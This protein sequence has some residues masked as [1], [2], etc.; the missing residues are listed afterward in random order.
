MEGEIKRVWE[1]E[2]VQPKDVGWA[3]EKSWRTLS[4]DRKV[5]RPQNANTVLLDYL[6]PGS[7]LHLHSELSS[8]THLNTWSHFFSELSPGR[9]FLFTKD[10]NSTP[11][12]LPNGETL[13]QELVAGGVIVEGEDGRER[14]SDVIFGSITQLSPP[15]LLSL[16]RGN[17]QVGFRP[18]LIILGAPEENQLVSGLL[19]DASS[20]LFSSSYWGNSGPVFSRLFQSENELVDIEWLK[21]SLW[22]A[23]MRNIALKYDLS[24]MNEVLS[25]IEIDTSVDADNRIPA[26]TALLMGWF[27]SQLQSRVVSLSA[28]GIECISSSGKK[29]FLKHNTVTEKPSQGVSSS[30]GVSKCQFWLTPAEEGGTYELPP[31][32]ICI[33]LTPEGSFETT[34]TIASDEVH[35]SGSR[36]E[37]SP[38]EAMRRYYTR[39]E[40]TATYREALAAALD[41]SDLL[42]TELTTTSER[43]WS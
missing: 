24:R 18:S 33:Q 31:S 22:R 9:I 40:S 36:N 4:S 12:V 29:W 17:L 38:E 15:V 2:P 6:E 30:R 34:L 8:E 27:V 14:Y 10:T 5:S 32:A 20:I 42:Y 23:Q 21:V 25:S 1:L 19:R 16:V 13:A 11:A 41:I 26:E 43:A 7:P 35:I 37:R 3:L 28:K 39:G